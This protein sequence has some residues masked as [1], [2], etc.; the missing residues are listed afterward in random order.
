M[1]ISFLRPFFI[2]FLFSATTIEGQIPNNGFEDWIDMGNYYNPAGWW[3]TNDSVLTGNV[4]P[5]TRSTDHYPP[6]IGAYS[7]KMQ[8]NPEVYPNWASMGLAWTGDFN[9]N[10]NPVFPVVGQPAS[11]WGYFK[12]FPQAND[13]FEIH[14]RLFEE[15]IDVGG[16]SF[17]TAETVAD[18][19]SFKI[20]LS[21]YEA[22]DS[23]RILF[24]TCFDNDEPIPHG[25][26]VLYLDNLS[27]D[28]LLTV[29]TRTIFDQKELS[30]YPVPAKNEIRL[31]HESLTG[32]RIDLTLFDL[33][34]RPVKVQTFHHFTGTETINVSDLPDGI[35]FIQILVDTQPAFFREIIVQKNG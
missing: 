8:N 6:S 21:D 34:I 11:L 12:F 10:N 27:F 25:Q 15:G 4:F 9:G 28:S 19:S 3:T 2:F 24:S 33:L 32:K 14:I 26:S 5:V 7:L 1:K 35:Y 22:A 20:T 23:A 13:T 17:K 18:W 31:H 16:G 30:L 29:E